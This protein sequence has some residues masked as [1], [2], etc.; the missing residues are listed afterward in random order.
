MKQNKT[1]NL[2]TALLVLTFATSSALG[3]VINWDLTATANETMTSSGNGEVTALQDAPNPYS[4]SWGEESFYAPYSGTITINY[5]F[6]LPQNYSSRHGIVRFKTYGG[7]PSGEQSSIVFQT[8]SAG[9][10]TG[11]VTVPFTGGNTYWVYVWINPTHAAG[12]RGSISY[13][14]SASQT[15]TIHGTDGGSPNVGLVGGSQVVDAYDI[16]WQGSSGGPRTITQFNLT[17]QAADVPLRP[18]VTV[19]AS[20]GWSQS[21]NVVVDFVNSQPTVSLTSPADGEVVND[22]TPTFTFST[23]DSDGD[24]QYAFQLQ[25][26]TN[27]SFNPLAYDTGQ[28]I[29][30]SSTFTLPGANALTERDY[31]WRVHAMD[32]YNSGTWGSWSTPRS[33]QNLP[34]IEILGN[35]VSIPSGD[36][37]PSPAD[38]TDF[39]AVLVGGSESVTHV[40]TVQNTGYSS[41][42]LGT[43]VVGGSH[44]GDFAV[45]NQ[46]ESQVGVGEST[47]FSVCFTP[48]TGGVRLATLSL[49]NND[50]DENPF[51]F[52]IQGEGLEQDGSCCY[53]DGSCQVT[54]ETACTGIWTMFGICEPNPCEQP[55]GACC[56]TDGTCSVTF[57][58]DCQTDEWTIFEV[59]EPNPCEQ[60]MGSC[61][62]PDGT[63]QEILETTCTG[64][65]EMFGSCDPNLCPQ[66]DGACCFSNGTCQVL[67]QMD[68]MA[69]G[70]V[71]WMIFDSC[72]PNLCPSPV[73]ACCFENEYCLPLIPEECDGAGGSF[74]GE[75]TLCDPNPCTNGACYNTI[76]CECFLTDNE[77]ECSPNGYEHL[78]FQGLGTTCPAD[79]DTVLGAC[80]F[81]DGCMNLTCADCSIASG[82][83]SGPGTS[84]DT[85]PCLAGITDPRSLPDDLVFAV[86]TLCLATNGLNYSFSLPSP[87][88]VSVSVIDVSGALVRILLDDEL[89]AGTYQRTWNQE[90]GNGNG[91]S[92]GVYFLRL[93]TNGVREVRKFILTK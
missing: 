53:T 58:D 18:R 8:T 84:C 12:A 25:I 68:C 61:C 44:A 59:C 13:S 80:W 76:E 56:Y 27:A 63:C 35:G 48:T 70:G 34:E 47:T 89:H 41:L 73:G 54:S 81:E 69:A 31:Y 26:S 10:T 7:Y 2:V 92:S 32:V 49:S 78:Q 15:T 52:S 79:P 82:I 4:G 88:K 85:D 29:T 1:L 17:G 67:N 22:Q 65:W 72:E 20:P 21:G 57:E 83:H 46:P 55:T 23:N 93:D 60:P 33:F 66:P 16:M 19:S 50:D 3:S 86:P 74:L 91:L 42:T 11:S 38:D 71:E 24:A 87:G 62:Y 43:V 40:F 75:G 9:R 30:T 39:G 28:Q 37:S 36:S 5:D 64:V 90:G 6:N 45:I 77:N 14:W 51:T